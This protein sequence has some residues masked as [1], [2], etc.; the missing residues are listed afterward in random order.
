LSFTIAEYNEQKNM[1]PNFAGIK[2]FDYTEATTSTITGLNQGSIQTLDA[3]FMPYLD[4]S[5]LRKSIDGANSGK[6]GQ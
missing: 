1:S 4:T 5:K 6:I 2:S 3:T